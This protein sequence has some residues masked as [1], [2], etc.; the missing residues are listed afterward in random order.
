MQRSK[1]SSHSK[2]PDMKLNRESR[3]YDI[4]QSDGEYLVLELSLVGC[5]TVYQPF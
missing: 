4:K 3:R 5:F 2:C 1:T